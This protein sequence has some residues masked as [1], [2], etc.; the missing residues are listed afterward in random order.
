VEGRDLALGTPLIFRVSDAETDCDGQR[1]FCGV[2][3][4]GNVIGH[5]LFRGKEREEV[6]RGAEIA[7][8]AEQSRMGE[9]IE[10]VGCQSG[11]LRLKAAIL[12]RL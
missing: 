2:W 11:R 6:R 5:L 9:E 8:D 4:G 12:G 1:F 7:K 10:G 3:T